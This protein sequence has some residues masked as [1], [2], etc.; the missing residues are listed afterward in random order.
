MSSNSVGKRWRLSAASKA[1]ASMRAMNLGA[2]L[3]AKIYVFWGGRICKPFPQ[4]ISQD[5]I[6]ARIEHNYLK[7]H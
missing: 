6:A 4:V 2:E 3:G 1:V 5:T 7:L